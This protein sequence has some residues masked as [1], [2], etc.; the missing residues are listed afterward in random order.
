MTFIIF[1]TLQ[2]AEICHIKQR[3]FMATIKSET[4]IHINTN[5]SDQ[6][7]IWYRYI[8][9]A[10]KQQTS[11][12]FWW[13]VSLLIHCLLVPFSFLFSTALN[14]PTGTILGISMIL[15]FINVVGNMGG[16]STR[17]TILAFFISLAIHGLM[18]AAVLL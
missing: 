17:F 8:T 11:H 3:Q 15:F 5:T 2:T 6:S 1:W 14:G 10:D 7:S 12:I 9:Y 16:A 18:A 4:A 13:L